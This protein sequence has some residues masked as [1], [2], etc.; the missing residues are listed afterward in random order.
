[1]DKKMKSYL[2]E[3]RKYRINEQIERAVFEIRKYSEY[4]ELNSEMLSNLFN[5]SFD[6]ENYTKEEL[7]YIYDNVI[8][9]L[10]KRYYFNGLQ[11]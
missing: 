4:Y 1:M 7:K 10:S 3:I 2:N 6:E 11:K 9:I 8:E 5:T